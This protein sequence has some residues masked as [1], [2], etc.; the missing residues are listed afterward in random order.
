M[1][2]I[3]LLLILLNLF[4]LYYSIIELP[5]YRVFPETSKD[6]IENYT[7]N[8]LY[9]DLEIGTP[10]QK[11]PFKFSTNS[12]GTYVASDLISGNFEK[13]TDSL[14]RTFNL[15]SDETISFHIQPV[16][17]GH[18]GTDII[19]V[20][21]YVFKDIKFIIADRMNHPISGAIGLK[22]QDTHDEK[23]HQCNFIKNLKEKDLINSYAFTVYYNNE[24]SGNIIIGD[25][26]HVFNKTFY[27]ID[28]FNYGSAEKRSGNDIEWD[29][30]FYNIYYGNVYTDINLIGELDMEFGLLLAPEPFK[31]HI[32]N[33]FFKKY[34][35]SRICVLKPG[36]Y[37]YDSFKYYVCKKPDPTEKYTEQFNISQFEN[38]TFVKREWKIN[39]TFTKEELFFEDEN[40]YYFKI[41]IQEK[42]YRWI[43]GNLFSNK[44]NIT[45]DQDRKIIGTYLKAEERSIIKKIQNNKLIYIFICI[46]IFIIIILSYYLFKIL[47]QFVRK[48]RKYEIIDEYETSINYNDINKDLIE[49]KHK[50]IEI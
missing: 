21:D 29:I 8:N 48:K 13:F 20:N 33:N 28:D 24:N 14:S 41:V 7:Y 25:L 45:Y 11:I 18:I 17:D 35:I 12:F 39:V 36:S 43:L 15:L 3:N 44:V 6:P 16:N 1:N 5:F 47:T 37:Y 49:N 2:Y 38:I 4:S 22:A 23:V 34:L 19:K 50:A 9:I 42:A 40:Y 10:P 30:K 32:E 26:P 46:A 31:I 27:S